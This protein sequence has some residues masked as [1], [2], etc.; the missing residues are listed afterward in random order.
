MMPESR[1]MVRWSSNSPDLNPK[2]NLWAIMKREIKKQQPKSIEE[3]KLPLI[4]AWNSITQK[5][6]DNLIDSMSRNDVILFLF[7]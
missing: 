1:A 7:F 4:D 3:L 6:I 5:H 2:E